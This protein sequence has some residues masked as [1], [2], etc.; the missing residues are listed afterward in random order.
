M[1]FSKIQNPVFVIWSFTFQFVLITHFALRRTFLN[2]A[3]E[4]GWIVYALSLFSVLVSFQQINRR[5]SWSF[6]V[7]GFIF[8]IWAVFGFSVEYL[9]KVSWRSPI[10]WNIFIPYVGLYLATIMFYWWPLGEINKLLWYIYS[11]L[12]VISTFFNITSHSL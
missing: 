2:F 12:F 8:L 10:I 9:F 4:Y 3:I 7:G 6:W 1:V 11:V 5:E